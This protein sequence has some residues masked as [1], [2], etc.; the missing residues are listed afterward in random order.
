MPR[1]LVE[2]LKNQVLEMSL[3]EHAA[4]TEWTAARAP[5]PAPEL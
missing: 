3:I 1:L 4:A 2:K 5:A